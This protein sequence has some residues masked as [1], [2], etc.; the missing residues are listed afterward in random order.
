MPM[1]IGSRVIGVPPGKAFT[2]SDPLCKKKQ[3][4]TTNISGKT[5]SNYNTAGRAHEE[6]PCE[7]CVNHPDI[8]KTSGRTYNPMKSKR[9]PS[10]RHEAAAGGLRSTPRREKKRTK[11]ETTQMGIL[12]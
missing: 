10:D 1:I 7:I 9:C 3:I 4:L 11:K 12:R 2:Y 5:E 8:I 6:E